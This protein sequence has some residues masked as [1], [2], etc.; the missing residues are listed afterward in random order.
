MPRR[1]K[2][3]PQL[4]TDTGLVLSAITLKDAIARLAPYPEIGKAVSIGRPEHRAKSVFIE[5]LIDTNEATGVP[6]AGAFNTG[7]GLHRQ[8][9]LRDTYVIAPRNKKALA[10]NWNKI[11]PPLRKGKKVN[12]RKLLGRLKDGRYKFR[13]VDHPGV[14]GT[15]YTS[16]AIEESRDEIKDLLGREALKGLRIYLRANLVD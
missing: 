2:K 3:S 9:G 15:N 6:Y 5:V 12:G 1:S 13:Y 16:A 10:F 4:I 8:R 7:S 11:K 14:E